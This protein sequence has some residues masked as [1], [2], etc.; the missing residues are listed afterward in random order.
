M[1]RGDLNN[2][3][4]QLSCGCRIQVRNQPMNAKATYPCRAGKGHGYS[5]SWVS[6]TDADGR[7]GANHG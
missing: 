7:T 3:T 2:V 4:V 5:L 1:A 6:W